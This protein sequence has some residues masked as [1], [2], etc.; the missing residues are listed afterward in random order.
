MTE[1][2][3]LKLIVAY[4]RS[5]NECAVVKHNQTQSEVDS[6]LDQ[7]SRH[8]RPDNSFIVLAQAQRHG[9][10]DALKCRA[11]RETVLRSGQI[12]PKPKFKR[13]EE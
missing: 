7:W 10:E 11:C 1:T 12:E 2:Q 9:T 6:Y 8:L 5:R 13:R 3:G 4:D